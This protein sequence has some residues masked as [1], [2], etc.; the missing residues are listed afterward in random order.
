MARPLGK[1][2]TSALRA[3]REHRGY[4][5]GCGW[6]WGGHRTT[7]RL[8]DSLVARGLAFTEQWTYTHPIFKTP[9]TV[10]RYRAV[11]QGAA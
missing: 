7:C 5:P 3:L 1:N 2:Q 10:T 6:V 8:L 4:Y 11:E 9:V